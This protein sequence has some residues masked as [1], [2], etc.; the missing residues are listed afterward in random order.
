MGAIQ[1][2][3]TI[4]LYIIS[5]VLSLLLAITSRKF[6]DESIRM[7]LA[8]HLVLAIFTVIFAFTFPGQPISEYLMLFAV[9]S[10]LSLSV[11]ALK[12]QYLSL[13]VKLYLGAYLLTIGLF[14]WSPSLLFYSISGNYGIYRKEQQFNLKENYYLVEQQSMIKTI[15]LPVRYK[16]IQKFGI[17][18]KT[19]AR[20]LDFGNTLASAALVTLND[21][22][23]IIE[24]Q[25]I[26]SQKTRIGIRPGF[27]SKQI[28]RK[29]P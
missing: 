5:I 22:T 8:L 3:L 13:P 23:L 10:G 20:D 2:I 28:T 1:L 19:L 6:R 24:G 7:P 18:N 4:C 17:Y 15:D 21:D 11:W 27:K 29:S 9:C 12:N 26:N 25:Y 14:F 16:V